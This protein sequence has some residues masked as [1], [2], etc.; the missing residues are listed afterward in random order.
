MIWA[1]AGLVRMARARAGFAMASAG[2]APGRAVVRLDARIC[3][4][5]A[6][7]LFV[8][9]CFRMPLQPRWILS[10][11]SSKTPPFCPFSLAPSSLAPTSAQDAMSLSFKYTYT[12]IRIIPLPANRHRHDVVEHIHRSHSS[13]FYFVWSSLLYKTIRFDTRL[14]VLLLFLKKKGEKEKEREKGKKKRDE[15][16]CHVLY[17]LSSESLR[18]L[19]ERLSRSRSRPR[20]CRSRS[21]ERLLQRHQKHSKLFF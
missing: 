20:L 5:F 11:S 16:R 21:L 3:A 1:S 14:F 13:G 15:T 12:Y 7:V 18:D 10:K 2:L 9:T 4:V 19:R 8:S 17:L 6:V